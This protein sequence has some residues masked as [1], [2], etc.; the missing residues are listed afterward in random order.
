MTDDNNGCVDFTMRC[1]SSAE[2]SN[3]V[4]A[5]YERYKYDN[6]IRLMESIIY[7]IVM[8]FKTVLLVRGYSLFLHRLSIAGYKHHY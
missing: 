2:V 5:Q 7:T 3:E 4:L 8:Y 1:H 6:R